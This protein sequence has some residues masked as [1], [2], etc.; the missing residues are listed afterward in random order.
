MKKLQ[1][2]LLYSEALISYQFIEEALRCAIG[3]Q[4]TKLSKIAKET[5]FFSPNTE[6]LEKDSLGTLI[7]KFWQ[8]C[9]DEELLKSLTDAVKDR[10]WL[11]HKCLID[12]NPPKNLKEIVSK[13]KELEVEVES[14]LGK[15]IFTKKLR[16]RN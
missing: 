5:L 12:Q 14:Y 4:L 9:D 6:I 15:N 1:K 13:V 16:G 7:V 2:S 11:A 8:F 10:N 3:H